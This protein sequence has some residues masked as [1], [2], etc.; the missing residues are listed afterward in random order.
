MRS[1][2]LTLSL[3]IAMTAACA[4]AAMGRLVIRCCVGTGA[5][6]EACYERPEATLTIDGAG[7]G[8]CKEW[9]GAGKVLLAGSHHVT[10]SLRDIDVSNGC[11]FNDTFDVAVPRG[12]QIAV[13]ALLTRFPD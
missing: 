10:A 3:L 11:C 4:H 5:P 8:T 9:E 13:R 1:P 6:N 2:L 12:G 7:A